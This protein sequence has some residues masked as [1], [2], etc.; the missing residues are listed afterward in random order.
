MILLQVTKNRKGFTLLE[1]IVAMAIIAI[2]AGP[3]LQ[4]FLTSTRVGQHSY[5][6][7]KAN[8]ISVQTVEKLKANPLD[9]IVSNFTVTEGNT[10]TRTQYY[11][12]N[13]TTPSSEADSSFRVVTTLKGSDSTGTGVDSHSYFPQLIS[14]LGAKQ[15]YHI[16]ADYGSMNEGDYALTL[17]HSTDTSTYTLTTSQFILKKTLAGGNTNSIEIPAADCV[18][19]VIPLRVDIGNPPHKDIAF[20]VNNQTD[21]TLGFYIYGDNAS[22]SHFI[23]AVP[24]S[25]TLTVNYMKPLPA[26]LKFDKLD[27]NVKVFR[28]KDASQVTDYTTMIYLPE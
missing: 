28:Q 1:I 7:D 17:T 2:I 16:E 27:V 25:G 10:F 5:E 6:I 13:G 9:D 11:D 24:T 22:D 23:T 8:T 12:I 15:N 21:M 18:S 14:Q 26:E 20:T 4:T 19:A 3:L